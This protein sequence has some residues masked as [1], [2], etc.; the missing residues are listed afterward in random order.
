MISRAL[1]RDIADFTNLIE[2]HLSRMIEVMHQKMRRL[3]KTERDALVCDALILAFR[4]RNNFDPRLESV[5][6]WFARSVEEA[7]LGGVTPDADEMAMLA[8]VGVG[9]KTSYSLY[10]LVELPAALLPTSEPVTRTKADPILK[11]R[12]DCPPCFRCMYHQG[13]LP[14]KPLKDTDYEET[15]IGWIC[16]DLDRRKVEIAH[17]VRGEYPEELL[18]NK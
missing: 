18:E 3:G 6:S 1:A 4:D 13:W 2:S 7:L 14:S 12:K 11:A 10:E 17:F 5:M 15:E 9:S 8:N 16:R